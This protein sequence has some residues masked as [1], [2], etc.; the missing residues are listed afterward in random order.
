MTDIY[1][2]PSQYLN[3]TAPLNVH[4]FAH[5]CNVTGGD[6]VTSPSPDSFLWWDELHPTEQTERV[7]AKNFVD[8]VKGIS[9]YATYYTG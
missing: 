7:I 3:G 9:K 8:V 4:G 2:N 6:C 1:N 5:R